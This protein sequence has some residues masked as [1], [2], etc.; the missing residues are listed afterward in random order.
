MEDK[1]NAHVKVQELCNC[2]ASTN[3]LEEMSRL[4]E[5]RDKEEA[6]LKWL[7]LMVLHGINAGARKI[8]LEIGPAGETEVTVKYRQGALPSP[9]PEVGPRV[10]KAIRE[11]T[12]VEG[13]KGKGPMVLGLGNDSLQLDV[14]VQQ[15]CSRQQ[16]TIK[17]PE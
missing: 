9:G 4:A 2:F 12:H 6:A 17:F 16:V 10:L 7:A 3:F 1:R 11:I 15:E 8:S 14:K 5:D 13:P